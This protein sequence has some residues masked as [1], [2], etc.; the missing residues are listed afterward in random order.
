MGWTHASNSTLARQKSKRLKSG[1][2]RED[3]AVQ[4]VE[5]STDGQPTFGIDLAFVLVTF[6]T[7]VERSKTYR[8]TLLIRERPPP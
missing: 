3:L 7:W 6:E 5:S 8:G 2:G 4:P 1:F